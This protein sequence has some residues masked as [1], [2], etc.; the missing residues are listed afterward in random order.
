MGLREFVVPEEEQLIAFFGS[1]P[2]DRAIDE[3]YWCYEV[4]ASDGIRL[5]FSLNLYEQS[6][7]TELRI[8]TI[9]LATVSHEMAIRLSVHGRDLRCEFVGADC[10]TT[11][12]VHAGQ[13]YRFVWSTLRTK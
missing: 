8:G 7:Q 1:E 13:E 12:T 10:H 11:L 6:V 3:G 9:S 2:I 5:R 4:G